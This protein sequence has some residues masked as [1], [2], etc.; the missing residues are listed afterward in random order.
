VNNLAPA[1]YRDDRLDVSL[2]F[3]LMLATGMAST[4]ILGLL[5]ET[6]V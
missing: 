2:H 6:L 1:K 3:L 5:I 4:T